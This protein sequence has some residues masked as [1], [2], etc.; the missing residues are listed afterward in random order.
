LNLAEKKESFVTKV[1]T[2][3]LVYRYSVLNCD[4][5]VKFGNS[6]IEEHF[7]DYKNNSKL[8]FIISGFPAN[9]TINH[10]NFLDLQKNSLG[11]PVE[12]SNQPLYFIL[13]NNYIHHVF[14]PEKN[15]PENTDTYL[16][17]IK[18]RYF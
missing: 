3:I 16:Q 11:L 9:Y 14:I 4:I 18:K 6:K 1:D 2:P 15:F 10:T 7:P 12:N 13:I 17:E 5:C 8:L